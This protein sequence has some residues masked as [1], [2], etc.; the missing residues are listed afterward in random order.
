[1][2]T[3]VSASFPGNLIQF[4]DFQVNLLSSTFL[5]GFSAVKRG[6]SG[7]TLDAR[8]SQPVFPLLTPKAI[9]IVVSGN[10]AAFI[11][12][13]IDYAQN[14]LGLHAISANHLLAEYLHK[15]LSVLVC[16]A[17]TST[18]LPPL[19]AW[20]ARILFFPQLLLFRDVLPERGSVKS[21][22]NYYKPPLRAYRD[23]AEA[24]TAICLA[25]L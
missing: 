24:C 16:E 8:I 10:F 21:K 20:N 7:R 13:K 12:R 4:C 25:M 18:W 1:M 2:S 22:G 6:S 17:L 9:K 23:A 3:A 19:K 15:M 14:P 5:N 11:A